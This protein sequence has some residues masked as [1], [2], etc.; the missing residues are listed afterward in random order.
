MVASIPASAIVSVAPSV[1]SAGGTGLALSGLYLTNSTRVPVGTVLTFSNPTDVATYFGLGSAEALK[2]AI[3]F[4]GFTNADIRPAALLFAQY[5]SVAVPA[6]LRSANVSVLP[7]ATLQAVTGT[8]TLV[9]NGVSV[10]S[11]AINLSAAT[12]FSSAA[13]IIAAAMPAYD[14]VVTGTITA[15]VLNVTAVASGTIA[16]GQVISGTGITAGTTIVSFGTGTGGT[17]TYTVSI[18]QSAASTTISAGP[19]V[20]TYD[21]VS[22]AFVFTGGTPGAT[23]SVTSAIGAVAASLSLTAVLGATSSVGAAVANPA[24]YMPTLLALT[25][26]FASFSTVF[27]ATTSD[28][29]A[30]SAWTNGQA[31]RFLYAMWDTDITVT[32]TANTASAGYAILTAK[33]A[34]TAMIYNPNLQPLEAFLMGTIASIDFTRREGRV[35]TCFKSQPGIVAGVT[36]QSVAT[37]LI[38]NGYNFYGSY[39]TASSQFSFFENGS[40]TGPFLWIDSYVNQIWLNTGFQLDLITL[41]TQV[42]SLPYNTAGYGLIAA[43][44]T[45]RINLAL[46]VG[47]IRPGIT[48]SSTQLALINLS[49]GKRI[50]DVVQQ[51]GWFL[52]IVDAP[53]ATRAARGS[54]PLTFYYT[55]GQSVQSIAL[56][57]VQIQ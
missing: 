7:L 57:S 6:Y 9:I 11:G 24:T 44:L 22:G 47:V 28:K 34:G 45:T 30:F 35:N 55:D 36:N 54:P 56:S 4:S 25:Q 48:L 37:Q 20:I 19:L 8:L 2:A 38:A 33:Y 49:A 42:K 53:P 50:S 29:I 31:N 13:A 21:S 14:A 43:S 27:E 17:G 39:A 32:T 46:L 16:V 52:Q 3:Y 23:A 5:P 15:T 1:L 26:A 41:L 51:R 12:G 18:S 40:V 10:T